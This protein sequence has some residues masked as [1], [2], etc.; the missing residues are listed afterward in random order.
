MEDRVKLFR[1]MR[2]KLTQIGTRLVER[3]WEHYRLYRCEQC[4]QYWQGSLAPRDSDTWYLYKVPTTAIAKWKRSPYIPPHTIADYL[5]SRDEYISNEFDLRDNLC[6]VDGCQV[7]AIEGLLNCHYHQ[8]LEI[9]GKE[10]RDWLERLTWYPPY[11]T[12]LLE[13][14]R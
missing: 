11:T 5:Q 10:N 3:W 4:N 14:E 8:W 13:Y 12:E 7:N 2:A 6:R 1:A 9:W